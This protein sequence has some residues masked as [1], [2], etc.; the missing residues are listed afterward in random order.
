MFRRFFRRHARQ[1]RLRAELMDQ[2][3]RVEDKTD[4]NARR[5][6]AFSAG[7]SLAQEFGSPVPGPA[8]REGRGLVR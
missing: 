5:L 2:L 3:K 7:L 1:A 8:L 6:D 4:A